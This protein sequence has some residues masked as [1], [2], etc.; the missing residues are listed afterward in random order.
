M[1]IWAFFSFSFLI[2][3]IS[4][5]CKRFVI[6]TSSASPF[7]AGLKRCGKSCRLRWMNYLRP[8]LKRGNYSKEEEETIIRLHE[9]LGNRYWK[10][11][12][13]GRGENRKFTHKKRILSYVYTSLSRIYIMSFD[14]TDG[15][16]LQLSCLEEQTMR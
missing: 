14:F 5:I 4:R 1:F 13:F 7:G 11:T 16:Q 9:S 2:R 15:L 12:S 10:T 3:L 8:N 6:N